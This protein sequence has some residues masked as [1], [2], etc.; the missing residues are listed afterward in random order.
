MELFSLQ[1][2]N[3]SQESKRFQAIYQEIIIMPFIYVYGRQVG[4]SRGSVGIGR[5]Q[6][7]TDRY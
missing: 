4:I 6:V 5:S 3:D 1:Y 2:Q 7:G